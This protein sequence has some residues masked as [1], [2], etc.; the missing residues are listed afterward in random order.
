MSD[1]LVTK[2]M[3]VEFPISGSKKII[4]VV[5][6]RF[7]DTLPQVLDIADSLAYRSSIFRQVDH[8]GGN[9]SLE[10]FDCR[11][12]LREKDRDPYNLRIVSVFGENKEVQY[13][14]EKYA[15]VKKE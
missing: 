9:A 6:A 10:L 3:E 5:N 1:D 8:R 4:E 7:Y 15:E 2:S 13:A 12:N 14:I 11:T